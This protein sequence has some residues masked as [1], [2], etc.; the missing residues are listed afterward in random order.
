MDCPCLG[1]PAC[2]L[3]LTSYLSSFGTGNDVAH[4]SYLFDKDEGCKTLVH[5]CVSA[6]HIL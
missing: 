3:T 4:T 1:K 2:S 5:G 6:G